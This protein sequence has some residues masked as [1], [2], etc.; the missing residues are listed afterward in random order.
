MYLIQI[1]S[2]LYSIYFYFVL[3]LTMADLDKYSKIAEINEDDDD[4]DVSDTED[5][6]LLV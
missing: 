5:P 3:A 4:E 2:K 6:D 1:G